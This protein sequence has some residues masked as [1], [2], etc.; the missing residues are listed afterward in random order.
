MKKTTIFG[1]FFKEKRLALKKGLR[2]FCLENNIDAGNLSRIEN[3]TPPP[4]DDILEKYA[5]ALKIQRNSDDW[6]RFFDLAAVA[7]KQIPNYVYNNAEFVQMLPVLFR[8]SET[9]EPY[10]A[11][12]LKSLADILRKEKMDEK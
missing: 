2:A 11:E 4:S 6:F 12:E 5:E 3:G 1:D 9:G 8:K 7:R 10:T